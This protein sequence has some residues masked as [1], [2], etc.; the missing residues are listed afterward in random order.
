[1]KLQDVCSFLYFNMG[2]ILQNIPT[3]QKC[4]WKFAHYLVASAFRF[5]SCAFEDSGISLFEVWWGQKE[6]GY[7]KLGN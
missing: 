2:L 7:F 6:R 3:R 1:M 5:F 4:E